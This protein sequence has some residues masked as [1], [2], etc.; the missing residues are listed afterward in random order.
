[1]PSVVRKGLSGLKGPREAVPDPGGLSV[2]GVGIRPTGRATIDMTDT[3]DPVIDA[4][5]AMA[6]TIVAE[7]RPD[8]D[9]F[10]TISRFGAAHPQ[11]YMFCMHYLWYQAAGFHAPITLRGADP[12]DVTVSA[13]FADRVDPNQ[14][15]GGGRLVDVGAM[16]CGLLVA[17]LGGAIRAIKTLV[18][19]LS[20]RRQRRRT[21]LR[22]EF[23]SV[24]AAV[25]DLYRN[26]PTG[27]ERNWTAT[28]NVLAAFFDA[29][30]HT[31]TA[32]RHLPRTSRHLT[33]SI[34]NSIEYLR[35]AVGNRENRAR[36]VGSLETRAVRL[37]YMD[38]A[39]H[40]RARASSQ[41]TAAL[42]DT[43]PLIE[44]F[45]NLDDFRSAETEVTDLLKPIFDNPVVVD[46]IIKWQEPELEELCPVTE[47]DII[48]GAC[49]PLV[50]LIKVLEDGS[51]LSVPNFIRYCFTIR[52]NASASISASAVT[53]FTDH[54]TFP[55]Y[56]KI[57]TDAVAEL[58]SLSRA[59]HVHHALHDKPAS[60]AEKPLVRLVVYFANGEVR[61]PV[62]TDDAKGKHVS[63]ELLACDPGQT[64][65]SVLVA[66][67][68]IPNPSAMRV[69]NQ[70]KRVSHEPI[71][72]MLDESASWAVVVLSFSRI[73]ENVVVA[74]NNARPSKLPPIDH[75]DGPNVL[76]G[77]VNGG[78][79]GGRA[80]LLIA[81]A[82]GVAATAVA[83]FAP[84][85][86]DGFV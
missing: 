63:R 13:S 58:G 86:S 18:G 16:A 12:L 52:R 75:D 29:S 48:H 40:A 23:D 53:A 44:H 20:S 78:E 47:T 11:R 60:L 71:S 57:K 50:G 36:L 83:S 33:E 59:L 77:A 21:E 1:M 37:G 41:R 26:I 82:A 3:A 55:R 2:Q 10:E 30:V 46:I 68:S 5:I 43:H 69:Y 74:Q 8:A 49:T 54:R 84:R 32:Q 65:E 15:K 79:H 80:A 22:N 9:P 56:I 76:P 28:Y 61:R 38:A 42:P 64:P 34:Q 19:K 4:I 25:Q 24:S 66:R 7:T 67:F 85:R 27:P 6:E 39:S 72:T 17:F 70:G 51:V 81:C 62:D 31:E 35:D 45:D 14:Q 73:E